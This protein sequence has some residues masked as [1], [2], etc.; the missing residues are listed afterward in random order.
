MRKVE[1]VLN[2]EEDLDMNWEEI[3]G[4]QHHAHYRH[5]KKL[6]D[7]VM[8]RQNALLGHLVRAEERDIM[9]EVS[10]D[11]GMKTK[12]AGI[13]RVGRPRQKWVGSNI[14]YY[15]NNTFEEEYEATDE[16]RETVREHAVLRQF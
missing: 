10:L 3:L 14:R 13:R 11:E 8:E 9:K 4:A 12:D 6:S 16:Q 5:F 7:I 15:W 2:R 1:K